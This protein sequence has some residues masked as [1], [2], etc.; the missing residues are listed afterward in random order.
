MA[1]AVLHNIAIERHEPEPEEDKVDF[2]EL[3]DGEE[4]FKAAERDGVAA[5]D[6]MAQTYFED[7]IVHL[8]VSA[9]FT[10]SKL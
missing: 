8:H 1:C 7:V 2:V 6:Y 10:F 9:L 4:H 3:E 5:R